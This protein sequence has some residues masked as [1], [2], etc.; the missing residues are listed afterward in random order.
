[1]S[2]DA[3]LTRQ[4]RVA[5]QTLAMH[6]MLRDRFIRLATVMDVLILVCS[7]IICA[8]TFAR[9]DLFARFGLSA[10]AMRDLIGVASV[11]VF[12]LSIVALR[13]DWKA[14]SANHHE[15]AR[16]L[17]SLVA[18][19]RGA[20]Q[21]EDTWPP[22]RAEELQ[23]MYW[24]VMD[25]IVPIPAKAFAKLK[26]RYLRSVEVSKMLDLRPGCPV[27]VLR[28]VLLS[29]SIRSERRRGPIQEEIK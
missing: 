5:R 25:N 24:E 28:I 16:K 13:V 26:A 15:A 22:A 19:Y 6:T 3:E 12:I 21:E 4:Y 10:T 7:V 23:R 9:D 17:T 27:W 1:M 2:A 29:R 11:A 14:C 18:Q 20:K 8:V